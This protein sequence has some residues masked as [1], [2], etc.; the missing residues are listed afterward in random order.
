MSAHAALDAGAIRAVFNACFQSR[1]D[2]TMLGGAAEPLY[3][4]ARAGRPARL[5]HRE[6]FAASALHEAAHWCIAGA[7]R[8]QRIDFG[9]WYVP[10][11]RDAASQRRFEAVEAR[12]QALE[13]WLAA[14]AGVTFRP[15]FDDVG[16][17]ERDRGAFLVA[18]A[19]ARQR[20]VRE[21]V[22]TRARSFAAA[23][24]ARRA[25]GL[26]IDG[27]V[28]GVITARAR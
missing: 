13:Q 24:R 5:W 4:P 19:D 28:A 12:P 1:Y 25:G 16:N 23:L 22:P 20:L 9:Y 27:P 14:A 10:A 7:D 3:E 18:F 15:S 17:D 11:P 26:P 21:G 6:D 2:V 8:R